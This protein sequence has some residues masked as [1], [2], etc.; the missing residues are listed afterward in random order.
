MA[1][2]APKPRVMTEDEAYAIAA[3]RVTRETAELS[4]KVTGLET[5]KAELQSKLDVAEASV[6]T[7]KAAREK[8]EKDLTEF[9]AE[10]ETAREIAARKD[11]RVAKVRETAKHLP[12]DFY[13]PERAARWAELD[14]EK[15][16]EY[17]AEIAAMV[18]AGA[19]AGNGTGGSGAP[20]QTAMSGVPLSGG[21][22]GSGNAEKLFALRRGGATNGE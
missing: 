2:D 14:E 13:T 17:L 20:R 11:G 4:T 15:F 6:A 3:D 5:E 12:D 22:V 1:D 16:N 21:D 18:P 7:E 10:V 9:K 19:G 8:A